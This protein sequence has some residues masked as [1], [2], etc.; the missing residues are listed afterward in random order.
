MQVEIKKIFG[1]ILLFFVVSSYLQAQSECPDWSEPAWSSFVYP[2]ID[3]RDLAPHTQGSQIYN[4]AIKE[5]DIFIQQHALHVARLLYWSADD[6]MPKVEKIVYTLEDVD[7]ISAKSG[8]PP[9]VN[10]FYSTRWIEQTQSSASDEEVISGTRGVL[11]H[12]LTH[13]YQLDPKGA[14]GYSQGNEH[15]AFIEGMADAIRYQA[16]YFPLS[17]RKPGGHWKDGYQTTGFFLQWLTGKD[18]DFL[19]K[20]NRTAIEV[21]PW[22]FDGAMKHVFGQSYS[23][24]GLWEEYQAFLWKAVLPEI[25][26]C[27]S[28]LAIKSI[29]A[30]SEV[31]PEEGALMAIDGKPNTKWC[32][33]TNIKWLEVELEKESEICQ[34][35]VLHGG[36]ENPTYITS[37]FRLRKFENDQWVEV[38]KVLNNKE[39]ITNRTLSPFKA[40]KIRLEIS[41]AQ[42]TNNMA[43]RIYEFQLFGNPVE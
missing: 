6:Y 32:A 11:Y 24:D 17:N 31:Q 43:A 13:A 35:M 10:I 3:F 26:S 8:S 18:P 28:K 29:K 34:W 14:G 12:E 38:D 25:P 15:W 20:F 27:A 19:R 36:T 9:V 1:I 41:K 40:T 5:P 16:G 30:S 39:N 21:V 4:R 33:T 23:V 42:Q 2:Q 37:N 7:G 22:S